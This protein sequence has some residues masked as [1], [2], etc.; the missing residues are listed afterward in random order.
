MFVK[1]EKIQ[2][3]LES[4]EAK[5]MAA[6]KAKAESIAKQAKEEGDKFRAEF[7]KGKDVKNYAIWFNVQN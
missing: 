7:A 4:I 1:D 3:T 6:S 5:L 2:K